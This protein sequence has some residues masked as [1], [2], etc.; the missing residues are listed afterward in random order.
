[1]GFS[2]SQCLTQGSVR[3]GAKTLSIYAV[4]DYGDPLTRNA[5]CIEE[6]GGNRSRV[7][8][9]VGEM[10]RDETVRGHR[11]LALAR[12]VAVDHRAPASHG[13]RDSCQHCTRES[14]NTGFRQ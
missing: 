1:M 12:T 13:E 2:P 7:T 10:A 14:Q 6:L 5:I 9:Y 4:V 3:G 8:D 11:H